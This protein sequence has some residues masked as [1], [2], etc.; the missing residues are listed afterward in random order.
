MTS[1]DSLAQRYGAPPPWRRPVMIGASV[2][3][4]LLFLGWLGWTIWGHSTPEVTSELE[5]YSV[6]SDHATSAVLVVTLADP[7]VEAT[8]R[9]R[10]YAEDHVVVGELSFRPDPATRRQVVEI[11]TERRATSV[12]KLGCTAP[13]QSR[14]R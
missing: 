7:D 9:L 1:Q 11:R 14:P 12:E 3:V 8:C 13:G 6:E 4:A 10:A 5:S 2:L